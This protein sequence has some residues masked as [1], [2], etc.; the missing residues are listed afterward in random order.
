VGFCFPRADIC[1]AFNVKIKSTQNENDS[2]NSDL[3]TTLSEHQIEANFFYQLQKEYKN[4]AKSDLNIAVLSMDYEKT[5]FLPVTKV[6]AEYYSRQLSI[7][8]FGVHDMGREKVTMFM[9][10]ENFTMKGPNKTIS[11]LNFYLQN[12]IESNVRRIYI[13][14]DNCFAQM[15]SRYLCLYYNILVKSKTYDEINLFY[16]IP[17]HSYL[18]NDCNFGLIE[19]SRIM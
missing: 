13:F 19:K 4:L 17:G 16:S 14:S 3:K 12:K 5:F 1:G 15:K 18:D 10:S 8:N 6:C 9:Y 11:L 2:I 7:H